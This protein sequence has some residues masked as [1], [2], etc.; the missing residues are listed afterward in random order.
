MT[1]CLTACVSVKAH[2]VIFI[3]RTAEVGV[4]GDRHQKVLLIDLRAQVLRS[5]HF[6][7]SEVQSKFQPN[8][9]SRNMRS[10]HIVM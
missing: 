2:W 7:Q 8:Q 9:K 10:A 6:M 3:K 4:L 1:H 5:R